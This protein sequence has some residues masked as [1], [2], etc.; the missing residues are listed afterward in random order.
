MR[1][2][3]VAL[4]SFITVQLFS[5]CKVR[6]NRFAVYSFIIV[7]LLSMSTSEVQ[8]K[9]GA[10]FVIVKCLDFCFY[11]KKITFKVDLL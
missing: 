9:T 10:V 6:N 7:Q 8:R 3:L 5:S 4:Y 2:S 11:V 1:Y